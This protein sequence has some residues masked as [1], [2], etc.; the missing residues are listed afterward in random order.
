MNRMNMS[1]I[2]SQV[3]RIAESQAGVNSELVINDGI[4]YIIFPDG[5][6]IDFTVPK[7]NPGPVEK[8]SDQERYDSVSVTGSGRKV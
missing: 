5:T 3:Q 8:K 7:V 4:V 2:I 1:I 6:W